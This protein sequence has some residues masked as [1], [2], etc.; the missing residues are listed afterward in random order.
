[1]HNI[2]KGK[3]LMQWL[4]RYRPKTRKLQSLFLKKKVQNSSSESAKFLRENTLI[5]HSCRGFFQKKDSKQLIREC[6]IF[7]ERYSN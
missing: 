7:E 2:F 5:K 1:M 4:K 3:D 6:E